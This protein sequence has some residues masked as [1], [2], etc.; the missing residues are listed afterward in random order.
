ML[1]YLEV[2]YCEA[3][4]FEGYG[5]LLV[6]SWQFVKYALLK[7]FSLCI[8]VTVSY[9]NSGKRLVIIVLIALFCLGFRD[10]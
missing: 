7:E 8:P 4:C 2:G 6:V 1:W 3:V 5:L 10:T 9:S